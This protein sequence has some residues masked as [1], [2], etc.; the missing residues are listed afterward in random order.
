MSKEPLQVI[1]VWVT[2]PNLPI[3]YWAPGS[4]GRIASCL[5]KPICI[6]KLIAKGERVSYAR[7]LMEM[8]VSLALPEEIPIELPGGKCRL[9]T[10]EYE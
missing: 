6:N 1:H 4:R 8:D 3:Q 2:F 9:Q 5:G 7:I 10:I